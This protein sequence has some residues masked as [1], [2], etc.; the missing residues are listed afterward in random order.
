[1]IFDAG[2]VA[3]GIAEASPLPEKDV[4]AY[5]EWLASGRAA[6]M[7][8]L[9]R[10]PD[11]R[12]DPR[13]LLDG[14]RSIIIAAFPYAGSLPMPSPGN[15]SW[16]R[17]AVGDDYHDVIR[18][19]LTEVTDRMAGS[20]RVCVDTAPL[21]ERLWAVRAGVG[22]IGLNGQLIVPSAGSYVLL[23]EIITT[24]PLPPDQPLG[25]TCLSC[26]RCL[27]ACPGGAL[28]LL[29]DAHVSLDARRCLSYITIERRSESIVS[30]PGRK[31][32]G[33]DVCQEVCP[34]NA[35][36]SLPAPLPEFAPRPEIMRLTRSDILSMTPEEFA[37]IFR[38]SAI[39][40]A[41]LAGL[42]RNATGLSAEG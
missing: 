29:P 9:N 41:K 26:G 25:L 30:L 37:A 8:Y 5:A 19:R 1:M 22:F 40:R 32:Y 16:A 10:Y 17:Y 28:E 4:T 21:R 33:C 15:L 12:S 39:K 14:A 7:D 13:K 6:D 31:V 34:H 3:V 36:H 38:R 35:G 2:A 20:S 23:G 27:E 42:R 18:R 11:V 24:L